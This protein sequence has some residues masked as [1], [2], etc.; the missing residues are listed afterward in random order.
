MNKNSEIKLLIPLKQLLR[1]KK[2]LLKIIAMLTRLLPYL[3]GWNAILVQNSKVTKTN[4][5]FFGRVVNYLFS[6]EYYTRPT[7][8]RSHIQQI[9]MG[10]E[11]GALWAKHSDQYR[12]KYPPM[13]GE[14]KIG[15]LDWHEAHPEV[16]I[17][18]DLITQNPKKFCVIQ[19]GA[20]SGKEI[21]H[22]AKSFPESDFIYT[23]IFESATDYASKILKLPNL[24]YVTCPAETIP[25][26]AEISNKERILIFSSGSSQ[27]VYPENLDTLFRLLS[28]IQNK[29]IDFILT[30]PGN[31][32]IIAEGNSSKS[33]PRG[34]FSYTHNYQFYAENNK[35]NTKKWDLI[36]PYEPQEEFFPN[37]QGTLHLSGWFSHSC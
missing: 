6:K 9:L 18:T 5:N 19:L 17:I 10:E 15:N 8:L 29:K 13:I 36:K 23:D 26:L 11:I 1:M 28:K 2:K 7:H 34:N 31:I 3:P 22:F 24:S 37:H 14:E 16:K 20:S 32:Q 12:K 25:A 27:Y 35:F 4:T 21:S 30:E 33:I